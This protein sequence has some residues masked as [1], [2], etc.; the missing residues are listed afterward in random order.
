MKAIQTRY[1]GPGNVRGSRVIASD[2]DGNRA[3]VSYDSSL[4][5]EAAHFVAAKALCDKMGWTGML[6]AGGIKNGYV[7]VWLDGDA[8]Y[9]VGH[10]AVA[11]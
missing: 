5:S 11:A 9:T 3:T 6:V 8:P 2:E 1:V 7:F 4:S 10:K